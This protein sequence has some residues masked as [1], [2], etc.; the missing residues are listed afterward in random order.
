MAASFGRLLIAWTIPSFLAVVLDDDYYND[1]DDY[2]NLAKQAQ[3]AAELAPTN[4]ACNPSDHHDLN[5]IVQTHGVNEQSQWEAS[6]AEARVKGPKDFV[7]AVSGMHT[8]QA[9]PTN[10]S[11][12]PCCFKHPIVVK[13]AARLLQHMAPDMARHISDNIE[14]LTKELKNHPDHTIEHMKKSLE[15]G[16]KQKAQALSESLAV[17]GT[18][19]WPSPCMIDAAS[20]I[21]T[22]LG[23][24][25]PPI[26]GAVK[27]RSVAKGATEFLNGPAKTAATTSAQGCKLV[28]TTYKNTKSFYQACKVAGGA[29]QAALKVGSLISG[30]VMWFKSLFTKAVDEYK[31]TLSWVVAAVTALKLMG[32]FAIWFLSGGYALIAT[33][34]VA[35]LEFIIIGV[36]MFGIHKCF[37][38][39]PSRWRMH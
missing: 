28:L 18:E 13:I 19:F 9:P 5:H 7:Q 22:L 1:N 29:A 6:A 31:A 15:A 25:A 12:C 39:N 37:D 16:K 23:L 11:A 10:G 24:V 38:G 27:A 32:Q 21:I 26:I 33:I 4:D 35:L 30:V 34:T 36:N 2:Q 14:N 17:T 8:N 20:L 3:L